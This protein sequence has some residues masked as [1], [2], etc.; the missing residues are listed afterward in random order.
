ML[1]SPHSI[2]RGKSQAA[3][4][5]EKTIP[6]PEQERVGWGPFQVGERDFTQTE[7]GRGY[8]RRK[9]DLCQSPRNSGGVAASVP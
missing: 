3:G 1:L 8:G 9:G 6:V 7:W 4:C 5:G 2:G